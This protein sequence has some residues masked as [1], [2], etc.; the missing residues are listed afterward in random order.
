V[1]VER[2]GGDAVGV[3]RRVTAAHGPERRDDGE[4][5]SHEERDEE[6]AGDAVEQRGER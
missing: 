1:P 3:R 2:E 5:Q 6:A 4:H